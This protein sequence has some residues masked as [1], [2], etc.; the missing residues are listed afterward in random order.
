MYDKVMRDLLVAYNQSAQQREASELAPW[1]LAERQAFLA[2]LQSEDKR[3]LLEVGAGPGKDSKFFQ[4][5]GLIVTCTDLSLEMVRLCRAKGLNAYQKDFLSLD[6]AAAS[7]DAIY[8][9]NCLL[10][11]PKHDLPKVLDVL[12]G[13]LKPDG[14]LYLGVYGGFDFEGIWPEDRHV[15]QRFFSFH[16]D[17]QLLQVVAAAFD[18]VLFRPI[19][20]IAGDA[21]HF[22]G[23]TL[24]RK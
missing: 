19:A 21:L 5:H 17:E 11:V 1:K 6:F 10:H 13:L 2:L 15:P 22:Q 20:P 8:A 9:L 14:L 7:F 4:D 16:T 23:L 18:I 12:Q 24:R 3:T